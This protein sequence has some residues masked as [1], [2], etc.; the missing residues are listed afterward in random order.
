MIKEILAVLA[1]V[2]VLIAYYPYFR[3]IFQKKTQ[4]HIYTWLIWTI[5]MGVGVLGIIKGDGQQGVWSLLL[6]LILVAL[7]MI[8]SIW[9]GT[10]NITKSDTVSLIFAL[11]ALGLWFFLENPYLALFVAALVDAVGYYP[12]FRKSFSE[13]KTE[14][15]SFWVISVIVSTISVLAN[16]NYNF[17]TTFYLGTML[18]MNFF[19]TLF[20]I[21]RRKKLYNKFY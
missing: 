16:E 8:L 7:V 6:G 9:Y 11:L 20:I 13:P 12:T 17:L 15:L 1:V 3:D 19:L 21:Y 5:T 10:K 2:G 18:T 4:P 14:T